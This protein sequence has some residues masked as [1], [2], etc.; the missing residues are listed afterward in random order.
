MKL[1]KRMWG[2]WNGRRWRKAADELRAGGGPTAYHELMGREGSR[3]ERWGRG[4]R[5]ERPV[6]GRPDVRKLIRL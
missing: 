3:W 6:G 1:L 2:N 5:V 4:E